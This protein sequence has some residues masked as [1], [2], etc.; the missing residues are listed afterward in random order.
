MIAVAVIDHDEFDGV[1]AQ[2]IAL[3][4]ILVMVN[5]VKALAVSGDNA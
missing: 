4:N 2:N 1:F 3:Q 5:H